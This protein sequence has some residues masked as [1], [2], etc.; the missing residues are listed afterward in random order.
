VEN[1]WFIGVHLSIL[2][3]RQYNFV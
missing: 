3:S 2:V 1:L